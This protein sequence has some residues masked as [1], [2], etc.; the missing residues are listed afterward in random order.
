[1]KLKHILLLTLFG[2]TI[3]SC[4]PKTTEKISDNTAVKDPV[5]TEDEP[6]EDLSPC[7]KFTDAP[8]PDQM[9]TNYVLYRDFLKVKDW[10]KAFELW[11]KVY[12][13]SPAADGKRS[14]VYR[15]GV[16]FYEHFLTQTQD[17]LQREKYID[18]IFAIYE[19]IDECYPAGTYVAARKGFDLYYT[20]KNRATKEEIY[21]LFKKVIDKDG[22]KTPDFV[23]NPFT[24]LLVELY[25]DS[26]IKEAEAKKYEQQILEIIAHGKATC[27]G[28]DCE[29]W[30]VIESYAPVRLEYFEVIKGFYDCDYYLTKYFSDFEENPTDCDVIRTVYSRLKFGG[31]DEANEKLRQVIAAGNANCVEASNLKNAYEALR[32]AEYSKAVDLFE[33]AAEEETDNAKKANI[34]LTIG[35]IYNAHLK[36]FSRARQYARQASGLRPNWGEPYILIGRLYASSGPLCGPGRGWDSQIVVWPAI[37]MWNKAKSVDPSA[38]REANKWISQYAKYMPSREDVFIRNLKAGDTFQV[39]CWIQETTRIRTAD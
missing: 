24:A 7:P 35:K 39:G 36:N 9:E 1:M 27:K 15:D 8:D 26:T 20:Y 4:T 32:N 19:Q 37:D 14:T 6:E 3:F 29:R 38:A 10:D 23:I 11:K 31:C 34:I 13:V 16:R 28:Q 25:A 12:D 18:E 5:T 30:E 21:Q 2:F 33:K 17:S 22:K